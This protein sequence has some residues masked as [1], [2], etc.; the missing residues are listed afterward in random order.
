MD[1]VWVLLWF[2]GSRIGFFYN[3]GYLVDLLFKLEVIQ[4][5]RPVRFS[6]GL[7][8]V[9]Y[10]LGE[11]GFNSFVVPTGSLN[12]PPLLFRRFCTS[13]CRFSVLGDHFFGLWPLWPY[14][15]FGRFLTVSCSLF[16]EGAASV[17]PPPATA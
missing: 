8:L 12:S 15:F 4:I 7:F 1:M 5:F 9:L 16:T 3:F 17:Q 11:R 6:P 10:G 14:P 2:P 13:F